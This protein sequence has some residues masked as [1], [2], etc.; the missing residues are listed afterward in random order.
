MSTPPLQ[1]LA[2]DLAE[3]ENKVDGR[4]IGGLKFKDCV[5]R[6][7]NS[8]IS[9]VVTFTELP[10]PE[11]PDLVHFVT[12]DAVTAESVPEWKGVA[13]VNG[14][15]IKVALIRTPRTEV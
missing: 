4:E 10:A 11:V 3:L 7:V 6:L 9:N 15:A 2:I 13:W 12:L 5:I 14:G 8:R 1:I